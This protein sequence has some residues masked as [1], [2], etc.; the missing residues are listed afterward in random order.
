MLF[1]FV[2]NDVTGSY[3]RSQLS[4]NCRFSNHGNKVSK[5]KP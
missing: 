2:M 1:R 5:E 4:D 3:I